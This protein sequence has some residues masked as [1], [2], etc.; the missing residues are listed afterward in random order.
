MNDENKHKPNSDSKS[1]KE[2]N[3]MQN[4]LLSKIFYEKILGHIKKRR[5][6]KAELGCKFVVKDKE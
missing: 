4:F 5:S 6:F 3:N 1:H 2:E